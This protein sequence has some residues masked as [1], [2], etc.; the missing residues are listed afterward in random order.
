M[1]S[2]PNASPVQGLLAERGIQDEAFRAF[3][4]G[5]TYRS[6]PS[7]LVWSHRRVVALL[8]RFHLRI[9]V[10]CRRW[11]LLVRLHRRVRFR[12]DDGFYRCVVTASAEPRGREL[13]AV[14][15]LPQPSERL[16][17]RAPRVERF[18]IEL[19]LQSDARLD[20]L[21]SRH[22]FHGHERP[23]LRHVQVRALAHRRDGVEVLHADGRHGLYRHRS[24]RA[25]SAIGLPGVRLDPSRRTGHPDSIFAK[26]A[27]LARAAAALDVGLVPPIPADGRHGADLARQQQRGREPQAQTH[28]PAV[29]R[30]PSRR[31]PTPYPV[32]AGVVRL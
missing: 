30:V 28:A 14:V 8:V 27:G 13:V 7:L 25:P 17:Q 29:C 32:A 22:G 23:R 9:V 1:S 15:D 24:V 26:P 2:P 20:H 11:P 31:L 21:L 18:Y 3:P 16:G 6:A 12:S 10:C 19:V 4:G 5:P